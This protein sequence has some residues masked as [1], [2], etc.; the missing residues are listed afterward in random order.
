[1]HNS[2]SKTNMHVNSIKFDNFEKALLV[3]IS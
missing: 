1:M 2:E 3:K